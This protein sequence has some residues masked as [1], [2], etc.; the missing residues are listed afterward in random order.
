MKGP[1]LPLNYPSDYSPLDVDY[2]ITIGRSTTYGTAV[3]INL[4]DGGG[5][6]VAQ[7][8]GG[9][10]TLL[11]NLTASLAQMPNVLIWQIDLENGSLATPWH[12]PEGADVV[13]WLALTEDDALRMIQ[14]A[15]RIVKRRR[16]TYAAQL[17]RD[18]LTVL[19]V[20]HN[21]PQIVILADKGLDLTTP[22]GLK[23][24]SALYE[25]RRI[26]TAMR[27][28]VVTAHLRGTGDHVSAAQK[29]ASTF[30]LVGKTRDRFEATTALAADTN[31]E[32]TNRG[33][34][35]IRDEHGVGKL[36]AYMLYPTQIAEIVT[37]TR[38]LRADTYLD[39]PSMEAAGDDYKNRHSQ[40][41][42]VQWKAYLH[43]EDTYPEAQATD[44]VILDAA[45]KFIGGDV[46]KK[47]ETL[48]DALDLVSALINKL[49]KNK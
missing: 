3:Q 27:V 13:D 18:N 41:A 12:L 48:D 44:D 1:Y 31:M 35:L 21:L 6:V 4:S 47:L 49:K 39:T 29:R 14:A 25:L 40:P 22:T 45:R 11:H 46:P 43:G 17:L 19:P 7:R 10:T 30:A 37:A 16:A 20:R 42:N 28:V 8:G 26:G 24:E 36:D 15:V 9:G 5:Y 32:I 38:Q 33:Q 34:L 2:P 23:I